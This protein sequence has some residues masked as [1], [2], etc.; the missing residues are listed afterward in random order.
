MRTACL[1]LTMA[2]GTAGAQPA[3]TQ[4]WVRYFSPGDPARLLLSPAGEPIV[5]GDFN[6]GPYNNDLVVRKFTPS[7]DVAWTHISGRVADEVA[8]DAAH[9]AAGNIIVVS[10]SG[11]PPW[12]REPY[13][14]RV[15]KLTPAGAEVWS[16]TYIRESYAEPA[17]VALDPAGNIYV[18]GID[19]GG[20]LGEDMAT[21][22]FSPEGVRLW[23]ARRAS[24]QWDAGAAIAVD[25]QGNSYVG[26]Q[27]EGPGGT[28]DFAV[29]KYDAAGNEQWARFWAG[30]EGTNAD[31]VRAIAIDAEGNVYA[32][33]V[34]LQLDTVDDAALMKIAPGGTVLWQRLWDGPISGYDR[35]YGMTLD[36]AGN[37]FLTGEAWRGW[38]NDYFDIPTI[39]YDPAGNLQWARLFNG[40]AA[41][42]ISEDM[43]FNVVIGPGGDAFTVGSDRTKPGYDYMVQRHTPSGELIDEIITDI[44]AR[45][46]MVHTGAAVMDDAGHLYLTLTA[47]PSGAFWPDLAVVRVT[48]DARECYADCN[49]DGTLNLSDFG[50]FQT[51]FA[52]SD[53]RADCNQDGVLNLSDFGCFQTKFALGC[54]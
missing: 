3:M 18:T 7:G 36:D 24:E 44:P 13:E 9:D 21:A 48:V 47:K 4:D 52:L 38:S 25:A 31:R 49:A 20:P 29:V 41:N 14:W 28:N 32:A 27:A 33:G 8:V 2:A 11:T 19:D 37:V 10:K 50:C 34:I 54:P 16:T 39:K 5:V 23:V 1:A 35:A 40:D 15:T 6:V 46:G 45:S 22:K 43:G 30:T 51:R 53:A 26:G 17:A 42:N 12:N